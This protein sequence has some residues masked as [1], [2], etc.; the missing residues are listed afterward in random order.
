MRWRSEIHLRGREDVDTAA[1]VVF[2]DGAV[3]GDPATMLADAVAGDVSDTYS[4]V[5]VL[6]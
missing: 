1:E 3:A 6:S 2:V 5:E 4:D